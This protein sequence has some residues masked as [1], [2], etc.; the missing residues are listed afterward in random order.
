MGGS[1]LAKDPDQAISLIILIG[2]LFVI[3]FGLGSLRNLR[4]VAAPVRR[5]HER[6][7]PA[8]GPPPVLWDIHCQTLAAG[9][10]EGHQVRAVYST[11]KYHLMKL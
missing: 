11:S 7:E 10:W 6:C 2:A 9:K 1:W 3:F 5:A 8:L 4:R